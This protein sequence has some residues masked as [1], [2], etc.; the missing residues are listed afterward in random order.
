MN[1]TSRR[2][3]MIALIV[4]ILFCCLASAYF[5]LLADHTARAISTTGAGL[6]FAFLMGSRLPKQ[7][8][9]VR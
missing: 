2:R 6:V 8:K 5:S 1:N 7:N 3:W 9:G 4:M